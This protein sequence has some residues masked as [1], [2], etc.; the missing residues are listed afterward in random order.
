MLTYYRRQQI[1]ENLETL[2]KGDA[3][4]DKLHDAIV[5]TYREGVDGQEQAQR[6]GKIRIILKGFVEIMNERVQELC[7]DFEKFKLVKKKALDYLRQLE[8]PPDDIHHSTL[9]APGAMLKLEEEERDEF[10]MY[11]QKN[12]GLITA[13]KVTEESDD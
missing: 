2:E 5:N 12:K 4:L 8:T 6:I 10:D 1:E 9:V 13:N 11:V 7:D 3:Y